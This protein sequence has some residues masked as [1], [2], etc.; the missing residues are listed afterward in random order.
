MRIVINE[1]IKEGVEEVSLEAETCND[2]ALRLYERL[3][4]IRDKR[5]QR[6][7]LSG[8]SSMCRAAKQPH[9]EC[10]RESPTVTGMQWHM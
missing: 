5:L 8:H 3:G 6:C 2:G 10:M 1:M 7:A 4:F 9:V